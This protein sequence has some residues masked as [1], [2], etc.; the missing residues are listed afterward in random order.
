MVINILD[1]DPDSQLE[2]LLDP[3]PHEINMDPMA[4]V[5]IR[6]YVNILPA[7]SNNDR[8]IDTI[9]PYQNKYGEFTLF[10]FHERLQYECFLCAMACCTS[11][12]I[13]CRTT[14]VRD[15]FKWLCSKARNEK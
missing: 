14:V 8:H 10:V 15:R 1:P 7:A 2:K 9:A 12:S 3:D 5:I 13:W 11:A 4:Y 6:G